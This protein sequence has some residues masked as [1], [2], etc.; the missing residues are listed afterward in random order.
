MAGS[1]TNLRLAPIEDLRLTFG[2]TFRAARLRCA[3][4]IV[5]EYSWAPDPG[6]ATARSWYPY[7]VRGSQSPEWG[8]AMTTHR[9]QIDPAVMMGKPVIQGTRITV[10]LILRKLAEGATEGELLED[11]PHLTS[12]DIRAAIAY[13]AA[14]VAHEEVVLLSDV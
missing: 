14:S 5:P 4:S 9:I 1:L 2:S 10:E 13:G 7:G 6:P 3:P 11:Y 12:D 8:G